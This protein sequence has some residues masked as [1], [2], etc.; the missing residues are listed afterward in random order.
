MIRSMSEFKLRRNLST[1]IKFGAPL[2]L[3]TIDVES[4]AVR[5][6]N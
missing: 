6:Y 2:P 5:D 4:F 3:I 1:G